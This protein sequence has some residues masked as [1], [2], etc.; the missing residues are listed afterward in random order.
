MADK[1]VTTLAERSTVIEGTDLVMIVGNV[2]TTAT[3]YKVQ[4]TN[5]LSKLQLNLP[6]NSETASLK[7]ISGVVAN[8][9]VVQ[10]A[11]EFQLNAG[12]T[13]IGGANTYGLV[14]T[15]SVANLSS[16][17]VSSPVAFL[18]FRDR[19]A[20]NVK[21]AYLF[22]AG[23]GANG[24]VDTK[25]TAN[26]SASNSS[27][28]LTLGTTVASTHRIKCRINGADYWLLASNVVPA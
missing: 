28:I 6:A 12:N 16:N 19:P 1:K 17:A 23:A 15:H 24:S 7:V 8:S 22:D 27:V 18:A 14:I 13:S 5:F 2:A 21:T 3:N 4:V 9:S 11:G 20:A 26:T 25:V 10:G